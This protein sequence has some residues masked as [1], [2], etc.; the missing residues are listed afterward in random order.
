MR[1]NQI[2]SGEIP[3]PACW[4]AVQRR[5]L[6]LGLGVLVGLSFLAGNPARAE[7]AIQGGVVSL[8]PASLTFGYQT[9][10]TISAP[11]T[12]T[13]ANTGSAVL[14]VTSI[15]ASAGFTETDNCTPGVAAGNTC[16]ISV[17]FAPTASGPAIG[18]LTL[19]DSASDSPQ[20]VAL[21]GTATDA[22]GTATGAPIACSENNETDTCYSL[23]IS[24]PNVSDITAVLRVTTPA[25]TPVGTVILGTGGGGNSFYDDNFFYGRVVINMIVQAGFTAAQI[26]FNGLPT[27]WLSGPG[28]PRKLACRYAT[29]VQWVYSNIHQSDS[30]RPMCATGNSGG[31]GAI[32]YALAHYGLDP[33]LAMVA[34]TSGPVMGRVDYGCICNQPAKPTPCGGPAGECYGRDAVKFIDPAYGSNICSSA[35]LTH[36]TTNQALFYSDSVASAD[37]LF[38]YPKTDVHLLF[39]GLDDSAA[40]PLGMEWGVLITTKNTVECVADAPHPIPDVLDGATTIANDL[41]NYC[42]LQ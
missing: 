25:G 36:D 21:S 8:S 33:I 20:T 31:A 35:E 12:V 11:Q 18:T 14:S 29:A 7:T 27:G 15:T 16:T 38:A 2:I 26:N 28:G 24:C 19:T 30:T 40:V 3:V 9:V 4:T 22:L 5:S 13:L 17:T 42:R 39:G 6:A 41:I 37:A 32:G 34:P 23:T 10:A 1:R